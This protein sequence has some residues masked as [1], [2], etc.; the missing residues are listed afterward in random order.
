MGNLK[1]RLERGIVAFYIPKDFAQIY[2]DFV[3]YLNTDDRFEKPSD[4]PGSQ[5]RVSRFIQF[6]IKEY[7]EEKIREEMAEIK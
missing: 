2:L 6:K 1:K 7:V 4:T 3:K 5:Q